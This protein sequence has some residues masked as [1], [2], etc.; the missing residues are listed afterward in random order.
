MYLRIEAYDLM[1]GWRIH[2][3]LIDTEGEPG[4]S[5]ILLDRI[6][7]VPRLDSEDTPEDVLAS[8]ASEANNLAYRKP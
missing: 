7:D 8:V 1:G 6:V 3:T 2:A 4:R 5:A